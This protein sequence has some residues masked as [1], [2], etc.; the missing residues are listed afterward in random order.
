MKTRCPCCGAENSL[1]ALIAH[2]EAREAIW[3]VAQ[4]SGKTGKLAMQYIALFR[5]SN[6][7][8]TWSRMTKLINE[9]LPMMTKAEIERNR[10]MYPAPIEAWEYAFE[11]VLAQRSSLKLPLKSHGYL[12][13]V[14]A[15]WQGQGLRANTTELAETANQTSQTLNAVA[16]LQGLKK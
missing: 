14:I 8:L 5:P 9:L 15:S 12:L 4:L 16:A 6:T 13:E 7:A 10:V 11:A 2:D 1:D 3:A